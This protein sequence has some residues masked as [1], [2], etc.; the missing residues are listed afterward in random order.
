MYD[1]FVGRR[2]VLCFLFDNIFHVYNLFRRQL[3]CSYVF[4]PIAY[5]MGTDVSDCRKVAELVGIKTF[6]NEFL[7]YKEL[8]VLIANKKNFTDYTAQWNSSADWYYQGDDI[9]LPYVNQTLKKGIMSVKYT[10]LLPFHEFAN[11][12]NGRNCIFLTIFSTLI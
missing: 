12:I 7:A 11:F 4:Y 10:E 9:V 5:F 6:T 1:L 2:Y 3:I 8:S